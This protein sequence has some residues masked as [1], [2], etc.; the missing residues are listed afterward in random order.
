V[1]INLVTNGAKAVPRG[2]QGLVTIRLGPGTRGMARL[3]VMDNGDGID[4][5]VLKRIFDPF[6]T[7]RRLG[8]GTTFTVELP[9]AAAQT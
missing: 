8:V 6:F 9:A 1:L 7:T 3:Q 5:D 4:P 2:K